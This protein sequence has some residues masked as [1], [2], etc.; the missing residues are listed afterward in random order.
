MKI[1]IN[2]RALVLAL[3]IISALI[4]VCIMFFSYSFLFLQPNNVEK[5]NTLDTDKKILDNK[6][7][8]NSNIVINNSNF[9]GFD[10]GSRYYNVNAKSAIKIN[11][12]IYKLD[13]INGQYQLQSEP[14]LLKANKGIINDSTNLIMLQ[15]FVQLSMKNAMINSKELAIDLI[16]NNIYS[17]HGVSVKLN[18]SDI[19]S[20]KLE[21]I[22]NTDIIKFKGNVKTKIDVSNFKTMN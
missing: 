8:N 17:N 4:I 6:H 9:S 2:Y 14:L 10:K 21:I 12:N 22:Q 11:D 7:N 5:L 19:V 20:D 15:E 18:N 13:D 16:N 1:I 3:K